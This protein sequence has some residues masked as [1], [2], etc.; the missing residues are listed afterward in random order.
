[1]ISKYQPFSGYHSVFGFLFSLW[2][3]LGSEEGLLL[4]LKETCVLMQPNSILTY[5]LINALEH[6]IIISI[7]TSHFHVQGLDFRHG[8]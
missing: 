7:Y 6:F 3:F 2:L 1:M 4:F 5:L 8:S